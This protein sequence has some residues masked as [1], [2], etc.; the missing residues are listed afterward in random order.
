MRDIQALFADY[1]SP[2]QTK[3]NKVFHRVGI[4][5]IMLTLLGMLARVPVYGP[6]TAGILLVVVAEVVYLRLEWRLGLVMLIISSG[7]YYV[8][9]AG[10]PLWLNVTLFVVGW[11]LQFVGHS[12][13]EKKAPAFL[14]NFPPPPV[15]PLWIPTTSLPALK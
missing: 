1:A 13:D 15:G 14:T 5:L 7:M 3:G 10:M 11:I 9:G 6:V 2:H 8:A 4:P 12:V